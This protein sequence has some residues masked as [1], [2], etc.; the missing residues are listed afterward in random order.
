MFEVK[1]RENEHADDLKKEDHQQFLAHSNWKEH[2]LHFA[3]IF[4]LSGIGS[5]KQSNRHTKKK[6]VWNFSYDL[7]NIPSVL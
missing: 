1:N 7:L 2:K 6:N 5:H 3:L 4:D